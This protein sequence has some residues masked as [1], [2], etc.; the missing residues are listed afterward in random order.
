MVHRTLLRRL[1]L[2]LAS[3]LLPLAACQQ[4]SVTRSSVEP[5]SPEAFKVVGFFGG[6]PSQLQRLTHLIPG[7]LAFD[8]DGTL[9]DWDLRDTVTEAHAAGVRVVVSFDGEHWERNFLPMSDNR[10]GSRDRFIGN[11]DR[12]CREYDIDGV[13]YDWEIGGGFSPEQQLLYSELV[14]ETCRVLKPT[15][16]TVSIDAYFRDELN[17][18]AIAAIDWIQLM[19]YT[20]LEEMVAMIDYWRARGVPREKLLIGMAIGW[21]DR[22]EGFDA[23][24]IAAKTRYALAHGFGGV[25]LF[26]TDLDPVGE[27]SMLDVVAE[28]ISS[29]RFGA[30][31]PAAP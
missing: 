22:R 1:P 9:A 8:E 16:R 4:A 5:S 30:A 26:R 25:M 14:I 10:D 17:A 29:H 3:V 2:I 15:G 31:A 24:L 7:F 28:T 13:D 19:C 21:G 18:D 11:L 12:F 6:A 23:K 27:H 20:D